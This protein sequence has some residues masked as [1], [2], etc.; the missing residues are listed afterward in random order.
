[1]H[2]C[3]TRGPAGIA[4]G[5][6]SLGPLWPA[7]CR[8]GVSRWCRGTVVGDDIETAQLVCWECCV[9]WL[10]A[11]QKCDGQALLACRD[12]HRMRGG[13]SG[14]RSGSAHRAVECWS[15]SMRRRARSVFRL[16][17][18]G[19]RLSA[20]TSCALRFLLRV[21]VSVAR[22]LLRCGATTRLWPGAMA[23]LPLPKVMGTH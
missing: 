15:H 21:S 2:C 8:H 1:M 14:T 22:P 7:P 9:P 5:L 16:P 10:S 11:R 4:A 17:S 13:Q 19:R 6:T 12:G 23:S 20:A 3:I 18:L